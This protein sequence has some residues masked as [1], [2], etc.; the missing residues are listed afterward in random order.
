[1]AKAICR[2]KFLLISSVCFFS[3]L[4]FADWNTDFDASSELLVESISSMRASYYLKPYDDFH[5]A[6]SLVLKDDSLKKTINRSLPTD[7]IQFLKEKEGLVCKKRRNGNIRE[8]FAWELSCLLGVPECVVPSFPIEIG[9]KKV[10]LQPKESFITGS[11]KK[12]NFPL[13]VMEGVSLER[14][15]RANILSYLLAFKDLLGRNIGINKNGQ[16]RFFDLEYSFLYGDEPAKRRP[17]DKIEFVSQAFD[18]PHFER[19][20]SK[21]AAV[22]LST[23]I[24]SLEGLKENLIAYQLFREVDFRLDEIVDRIDRIKLFSVKEG[25]SFLDFYKFLFP[26]MEKGL[27]K[28]RH[29]ASRS[30]RREVRYG[31]ALLFAAGNCRFAKA[32]SQDKQAVYEW[33]N[34]YAR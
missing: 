7:K 20:L 22:A 29:I 11:L 8:F 26:K 32:S 4:L 9:F 17:M 31:T 27:P 30:L 33:V 21:K 6:R 14:Y 28:I 10:I 12:G 15:W 1:M 5:T 23:F 18:W 34:T 24:S 25:V 2:M 3:S 13:E 16:M 19:P